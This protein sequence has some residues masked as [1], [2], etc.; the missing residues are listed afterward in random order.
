MDAQQPEIDRAAMHSYDIAAWDAVSDRKQR[1]F[2]QP[3][4][5]LLPEAVRSRVARAG[6]ARKE[7]Q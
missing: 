7:L 1:R 4:R 2:E 6:G 5:R 3:N